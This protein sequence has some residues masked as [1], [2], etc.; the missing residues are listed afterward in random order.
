MNAI[1]PYAILGVARNADDGEIRSAFRKLAKELHPDL[2]PQDQAAAERFK[3]ISAAYEILGDPPKRRQFDTGQI[4]AN[5]E[6]RHTYQHSY[7]GAGHPGFGG[8]GCG[9]FSGIF[10]EMFR[11]HSGRQSGPRTGG[12]RTNNG[13]ARRGQDVRYTLEIDFVESVTGV[14]KRVTMPEGGVLDLAVPEGTGDGQVLRLKGKGGTGLLG[15]DPGDAMV[16]IKVRPHPRF[17]RDGL[18]IHADVPVTLDEAVLGGKIEVST[19]G[20]RVQLTLPK[21][22]SSGRMFRLKGKGIRNP[23][24]GQTG[25]QIVTVQIV[26]PPEIDDELAYFFNVWKQKRSYDPGPR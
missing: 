1:D 25:D 21:G 15:G 19:V 12:P 16:E 17:K 18:D 26:T 6:P 20:S 22:T 14:K 24:T 3:R 7:A 5:G 2:N 9:D 13:F 8:G 4:D 23:K 10:D 11:A